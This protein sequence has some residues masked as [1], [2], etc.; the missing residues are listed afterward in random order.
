MGT[1]HST[2]TGFITRMLGYHSQKN[3]LEGYE[4]GHIEAY[5]FT[6]TRSKFAM[7]KYAPIKRPFYAR[8]YPMSWRSIDEGVGDL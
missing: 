7:R 8:E 6:P 2:F 5:Y 1:Y 4:L 3:K